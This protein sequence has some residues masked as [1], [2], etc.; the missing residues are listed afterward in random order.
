[1]EV[2]LG[3]GHTYSDINLSLE[4]VP[5]YLSQAPETWF[6]AKTG[7][8]AKPNRYDDDPFVRS[9]VPPEEKRERPYL[10][11]WLPCPAIG[12]PDGNEIR[13]PA[14]V[15]FWNPEGRE[16]AWT[17]RTYVARNMH[18]V[19]R[20]KIPA[21]TARIRMTDGRDTATPWETVTLLPKKHAK[22]TW[23]FNGVRMLEVKGAEHVWT[24]TYPATPAVLVGASMPDDWSRFHLE[25][26]SLR[27]WYFK[28]PEEC[29]EFDVRYTALFKQDVASIEVHAPDR[30]VA[31]LYGRRG[32]Q[33][34]RVPRGTA[35]KI[36]HLRMDV[37]GTTEYAPQPGHPR[38]PTIP[39]DLDVRGLPPYLAPTWEQWF[40]PAAK[41]ERATR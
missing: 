15:A 8:P 10:H 3:G 9:D 30:R 13:C 20:G 24:Y 12:D 36:W 19:K 6:N 26:G 4:G 5:P 21:E 2:R 18:A 23:T 39:L 1:V 32:E 40:S 7:Q 33:E 14:K 27:H 11:Y 31:V 41:E 35:G 28:V 16:L 38:F 34:I 17:L 25:V 22:Q 37:G 29:Q